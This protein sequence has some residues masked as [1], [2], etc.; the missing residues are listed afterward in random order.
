MDGGGAM[1]ANWVFFVTAAAL[2]S[3]LGSFLNVVIFRGPQLWKLVDGNERGD[4]VAPRSCCPS[5]RKPIRIVHLIPLVSYVMLGGKCDACRATI[6]MRYPLVELA[7]AAA[8]LIALALFGL[9]LQAAAAF[10]FFLFLIPLAA[11]DA[12]TGYLPDALT[13]PL[14]VLGV[15]ANAL[16]LFNAT[17]GAAVL[18]GIIG[19]GAFRLVDAVFLKL[20]GVEGLGQ[21]DAKLLAAIGAWFGWLIL[22]PVVFLAAVM[23]LLGVG[24]AA[25][26]GAHVD[27]ET[28]IPFGPALAAAGAAAMIAHG[29]R[30]PFFS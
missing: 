11:I 17:P 30:A 19:Y 20:R 4:F 29:L 12:E 23:A 1:N 13:I 15:L 18:G 22:P 21:G 25:L 3:V 10:I 2:G 7:G 27:K 9:T 16:D 28:P 5:C 8:G 14:I 26:R 6:P 24:V